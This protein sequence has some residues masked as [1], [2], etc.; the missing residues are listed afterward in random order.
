[1]KQSSPITASVVGGGSGGGLSL[2]ALAN[3]DVYR[4]VAVADIDPDTCNLLA[5]RFPGILTYPN[6]RQMLSDSPTDIICV[7]TWAPSHEE[8]V[9][10]ALESPLRGILVE[11]PL[12][13]TAASG[14][15]IVDAIKS[16][17]LPMVVPH[18]LMARSVSIDI[19]ERVRSGIVGELRLVEIECAKWDI[20]NA[21]IHWLHFFVNLTGLDPIDSV[22]ATCDSKSKTYRD[23]FQVETAAITLVETMSGIRCVMQTGDDVRTRYVDGGEIGFRIVGTDGAIEF[24]D[25]W[26]N[27]SYRIVNGDGARK[28]TPPELPFS[29]HRYH[30]ERLAGMIDANRPDYAIADSSLMALEACEAAYLSNR[31]RCRIDFPLNTFTQPAPIVWDPGMPYDGTGGGRDGRQLQ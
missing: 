8:V 4:L 28:I 23:G 24:S 30:L 20:I 11:K 15:R 22:L 21:G 9:L 19:L 2:D 16:R 7:S 17:S 14:G 3:S 26:G 25:V 5:E 29:G 31:H 12:G 10:D 1:M 27:N 13:H 6:H 18:N